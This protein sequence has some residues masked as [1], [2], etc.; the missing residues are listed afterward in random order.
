MALVLWGCGAELVDADDDGLVASEDCNDADP[1]IGGP[2]VP[3]DG[4]DNDCNP[5]T[6]DDDLDG[7][8]LLQS[9]DCD[10]EDPLAGGGAE[11][12]Y[13]GRDNDC[14]ASTPDDDLDGDG[15]GLAEDCDDADPLS[16]GG[17][18]VAYDGRDNDCDPTT[19]D[20]DGHLDADVTGLE[21]LTT[22]GDVFEVTG[23]G[24]DSLHGLPALTHADGLVIATT[25]LVD[26]SGPKGPVSVSSLQIQGN[27]ALET[28][29]AP[30]TIVV[31]GRLLMVDNPLLTSLQGIDASGVSS[32]GDVLVVE[33]PLLEDLAALSGLVSAEWLAITENVSLPGLTEL[34]SLELLTDGLTLWGNDAMTSL[35][36]LEQLRRIEGDLVIRENDLLTDLSALYGLE[37]VTG[38]VIILDNDTL[39][40]NEARDLVEQIETIGGDIDIQPQRGG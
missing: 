19:L 26:L 16:G 37:E 31:D 32:K 22:V 13:D 23:K 27:D 4:L 5:D 1:A 25:S 39:P 10:D 30:G 34:S 38:D 35:D 12:A 14:D 15:F 18:E 24:I 21:Q 8:G 2:E 7:D 33:N 9:I 36:G 29:A 17:P 11:V 3:Y 28:L 6:P 20:S 40:N